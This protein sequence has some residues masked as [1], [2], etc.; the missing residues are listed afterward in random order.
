MHPFIV[1]S[2]PMVA[3]YFL[4]KYKPSFLQVQNKPG[5]A[6]QAGREFS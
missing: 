6:G 2:V 3:T 5:R 1:N 4:N